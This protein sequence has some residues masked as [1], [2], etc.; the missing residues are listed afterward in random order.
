VLIDDAA[1]TQFLA[2]HGTATV[3]SGQQQFEVRR[4]SSSR[5]AKRNR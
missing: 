3:L 2:Y 5:R 4:F 1:L